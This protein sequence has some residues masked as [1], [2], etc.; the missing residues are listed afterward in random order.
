[1]SRTAVSITKIVGEPSLTP[2]PAR[3]VLRTSAAVNFDQPNGHAVS[4][5]FGA[6]PL[7]E[8]LYLTINNSD[9][10]DHVITVGHGSSTYCAY[11]GI[12]DL[13]QT[14]KAG[15]TADIGPIQIHRH[16]QDANCTIN[17]DGDSGTTGTI[18]AELRTL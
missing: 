13:T 14:V 4:S 5:A 12:G 10:A 17:V 3:G 18:T 2:N 6:I 7:S 1:M 8:K 15:L 11:S 9:T 16:A